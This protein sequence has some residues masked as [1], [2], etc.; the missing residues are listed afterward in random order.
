M[1][2]FYANKLAEY[3]RQH[4]DDEAWTRFGIVVNVEPDEYGG[5]YHIIIAAPQD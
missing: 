1:E 3:L 2:E 5:G 4:L